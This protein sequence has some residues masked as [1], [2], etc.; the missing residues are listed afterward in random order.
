MN[1][2]INI[3]KLNLGLAKLRIIVMLSQKAY[4][5]EKWSNNKFLQKSLFF[6]MQNLGQ[7]QA[8]AGHV[9]VYPHLAS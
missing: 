1:N 6:K 9:K 4:S 3:S 7:P 5:G 8:G 2:S